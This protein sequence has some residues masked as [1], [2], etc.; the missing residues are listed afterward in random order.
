MKGIKSILDPQNK[1]TSHASKLE[2]YFNISPNK[3]LSTNK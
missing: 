3:D 1:K 2:K